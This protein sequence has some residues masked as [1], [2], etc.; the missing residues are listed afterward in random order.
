MFLGM[1]DFNLVQI[2]IKFAQILISFAKFCPNFAQIS[3]KN[4]SYGT[5]QLRFLIAG[6]E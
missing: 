5:C 4:S 6:V 3:K 1:Q 2:L